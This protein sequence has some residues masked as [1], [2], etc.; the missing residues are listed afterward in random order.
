[1]ILENG[2][3][4]EDFENG[5]I[6]GMFFSSDNHEPLDVGY[7]IDKRVNYRKVPPSEPIGEIALEH[8]DNGHKVVIG[9]ESMA[10]GGLEGYVT[11]FYKAS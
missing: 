6:P 9:Y 4:R 2:H 3:Q 7:T 5:R 1:M 8:I 11:L 10:I